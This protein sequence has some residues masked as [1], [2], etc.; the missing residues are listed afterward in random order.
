MESRRK[1]PGKKRLS[2]KK[3]YFVLLFFLSILATSGGALFAYVQFNVTYHRYL[4]LAA[5]GTQHLRNAVKL[6]ETLQSH[7]FAL[8]VVNQAQQE[9][10]SALTDIEPVDAG[11]KTF[12]GIGG[13]IPVYGPR[14]LA[15]M[16][17]SSLA[18]D[19]SQ[20]G[21]DSCRILEVL[22]AR[23]HNPLNASGQALTM[24]DF[25]T[26]NQDYQR[27]KASLDAA[28][29]EAGQIQPGDV[30]FDARMGTLLADFQLK[31]PAIKEALAEVDI[32]IPALPTLFGIGTSAHYL[33]ELLD[34][35][36]LRPTGGFIGNY[37]ILTIEGGRF[38]PL[39]I[40][41]VDLLDKPFEFAGHSIVYPPNYR[42]FGRYLSPETWSL[43]DSNLDA[44][45]PTAARY[46]ELNYQREGGNGPLQGVM[47]ITPALIQQ[48]LEITGPISVP[49][50][51]EIATAQNLVDLIHYHQ[52]G[53]AGEG[54]DYI[55][56][57]DG[58][59]SLRKRFTAYLA[60]HMLARIQQLAPSALPR[61]M[62]LLA[63]A[64]Q[65]K[66]V[67][68]YF[69]AGAAENLLLRYHLAGAIQAPQAD[70]LF[71][72]DTN[73]A[74]NKANSYITSF[75]NDQVTIDA[76]G[77]VT[78]RATI[79]YSWDRSGINYGSGLY[80]DFVRV[81]VPPGS[82]LLDQQGWR[83]SGTSLEFGRRVW[84]GFFTLDYGDSLTI[85]LVWSVPGVAKKAGN[86][87]QYQYLRQRQAGKVEVITARILLPRGARLT[88]KSPELAAQQHTADLV[89]L[90]LSLTKD[91]G[92]A[93]D[94]VA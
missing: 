64:L 32:V 19:F 82:R 17:L 47:A 91:L 71:I 81:Y 53:N 34:S 60:E 44:D 29:V 30:T 20:A 73:V 23:F 42:W 39:H 22:I 4:A 74:A 13:L 38:L 33:F 90:N 80:K 43:R 75:V 51:H 35:T 78:H 70:S 15:S 54:S 36:E 40:L 57:P 12:S 6:L 83:P 92:I 26:I 58:H 63:R 1:A 86:N 2:R 50:Y 18:V 27:V 48:A 41:D 52:L 9:F 21:V 16:H 62:E 72:V 84:A 7:P 11:M 69:N 49:E 37:G 10:A 65:T 28:I 89:M 76:Q 59:S 46:G 61:F 24:A 31:I 85:T 8:Q 77:N 25:T 94:Y 3:R 67:Q 79:K 68:L 88:W 93:I 56:S 14:L 45:F 66:D 87:W 5:S 55:A